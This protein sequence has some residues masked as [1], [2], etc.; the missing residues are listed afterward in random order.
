MK[1]FWK[2]GL[3]CNSY[4]SHPKVKCQEARQKASEN[5]GQLRPCV[6][7]CQEERRSPCPARRQ[8]GNP[9]GDAV[10]QAPARR[11]SHTQPQ[12][13]HCQSCRD[14][15]NSSSSG[16]S[17]DSQLW[18]QIFLEWELKKKTSKPPPSS[19][20]LVCGDV[21]GN[22]TSRLGTNTPSTWEPGDTCMSHPHLPKKTPK[23]VPWYRL[24]Q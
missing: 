14:N 10:C 17:S 23:I 18:F 15:P 6:A 3:C 1:T 12:P 8:Q 11:P 4:G 22:W 2:A 24:K 20:L 13:C 19:S 5:H 9:R 16:T 21:L 7:P